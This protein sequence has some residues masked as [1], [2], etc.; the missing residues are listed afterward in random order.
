MSGAKE[1]QLKTNLAR[2]LKY[3]RLRRNPQISQKYLATRLQVSVRSI[4]YYESGKYLPPSHVLCEIAEYF[5]YSVED[6]LS[7]K[8]PAKKED[9]Q[10]NENITHSNS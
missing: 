10:I 6:L 9:R 4:S 3:L 7:N 5:G 2:N 1:E 8:L